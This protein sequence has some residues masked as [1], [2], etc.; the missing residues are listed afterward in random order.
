MGA[1]SDEGKFASVRGTRSALRSR[2]CVRSYIVDGDR[3]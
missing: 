3:V 1:Y 2:A